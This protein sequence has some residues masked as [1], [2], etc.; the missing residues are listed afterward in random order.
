MTPFNSRML[1]HSHLAHLET[2]YHPFFPSR[3]SQFCAG[4]GLTATIRSTDDKNV[5][6][7]RRSQKK[8]QVSGMSSLSSLAALAP[9]SSTTSSTE[10]TGTISRSTPDVTSRTAARSTQLQGFFW[11]VWFTTI[12]EHGIHRRR[13]EAITTPIATTGLPILT[14]ISRTSSSTLLG[15]CTGLSGSGG[16][17][18]NRGI[19]NTTNSIDSPLQNNPTRSGR[20]HFG[21]A[22]PPV[23]LLPG[24][25]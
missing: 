12:F 16:G 4:R 22:F 21:G 17:G 15:S 18:P 3:V 11:F 9:R 25:N 6:V 7:S 8:P 24:S 10:G 19:T 20:K 1:V 13:I 5:H 2:S 23:H 14:R